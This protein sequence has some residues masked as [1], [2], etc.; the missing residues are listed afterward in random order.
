MSN[1]GVRVGVAVVVLAAASVFDPGVRALAAPSSLEAAAKAAAGKVLGRIKADG[2]GVSMAV[3]QQG[4]VI[5]KGHKGLANVDRRTPLNASTVFDL[6]S[7]S[8]QFTAM[9]TMIAAE[10]KL[11]SLKDDIRR[12]VPEIPVYD[13]ARPITI[14]HL[15]HMTSG[16]AIYTDFMD[17]LDGV[18]NA[19]VARRV[20]KRKLNFPTGSKH[21]YSNTDY[22]LLALIVERAAKK[23]FATFARDT[24]FKPAGMKRSMVLDD[25][26]KSVPGRAQGYTPAKGKSFEACREDTDVVGDGQVFSTLD[27][28]I[29]WDRALR[30]HTLVKRPMGQSAFV[31]G[32]TSKGKPTG[33]GFGWFVAQHEGVHFLSHEG[34]WT[35]TNTYVSRDLLEDVSLI[36][37]S[38]NDAIDAGALG[39]RM[40]E[41]LE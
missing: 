14:A 25:V 11:L 7:C 10:K 41:A 21:E 8:K 2:P 34:V 26:E 36:I 35:G 6:A 4:R 31:S 5:Y 3:I 20:G 38:N 40:E 29:A 17:D 28:M 32:R 39:T 24:I 19:E 30:Q 15:L 33:Y 27:D 23:P 18:D 9:A 1:F 13:K 12:Y 16:L 37:L 22:A